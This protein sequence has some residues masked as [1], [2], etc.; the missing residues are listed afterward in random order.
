MSHTEDTNVMGQP[1]QE[2]YISVKLEEAEKGKAS[3]SRSNKDREEVRQL[4]LTVLGRERG[5][6]MHP[7]NRKQ[8]LR[9]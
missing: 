4:W 6:E 2:Q 9:L 8:C 3:R 1:K 7:G 5:K